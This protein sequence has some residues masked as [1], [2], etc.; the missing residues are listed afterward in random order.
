M[1]KLDSFTAEMIEAFV[2]R[3]A[4]V[5]FFRLK[6]EYAPVAGRSSASGRASR[7]R[8][9]LKTWGADLLAWIPPEGER[10]AV[11]IA[12]AERASDED[13]D[14]PEG[15]AARLKRISQRAP[16]I[17]PGPGWT[18][19][20]VP[21]LLAALSGMLVPDSGFMIEAWVGGAKR[22]ADSSYFRTDGTLGTP[23]TEDTMAEAA[24]GVGSASTGG[25]RPNAHELA[26]SGHYGMEAV[27]LAAQN[28]GAG[29]ERVRELEGRYDEDKDAVR[30]LAAELAAERVA[31]ELENRWEPADWVELGRGLI[32]QLPVLAVALKPFAEPVGRGVREWL[33][34]RTLSAGM[35]RMARAARLLQKAGVDPKPYMDEVWRSLGP[36]RG[37]QVAGKK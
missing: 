17:N 8:G 12:R 6:R 2:K 36:Q 30:L 21:E 13:E 10:E 5:A 26:V 34:V 18:P 16:N 19:V 1:V 14:E 4:K 25:G 22:P 20:P 37:D 28:A 31:R 33:R 11:E 9:T 15:I 23:G 7:S 32:P 3:N 27:R 35:E 24:D 29:W